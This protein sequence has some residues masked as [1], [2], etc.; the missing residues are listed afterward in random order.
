MISSDQIF[1]A[2]LVQYVGKMS[3]LIWKNLSIDMMY[4]NVRFAILNT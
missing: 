2:D 1:N 3:I 4:V